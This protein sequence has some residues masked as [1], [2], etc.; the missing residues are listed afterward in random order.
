MKLPIPD[1]LGFQTYKKL[2]L[3][4]IRGETKYPTKAILKSELDGTALIQDQNE[5]LLI[6][7]QCLHLLQRKAEYYPA[8]DNNDRE[9]VKH[10]MNQFNT[11]NNNPDLSFDDYN[12]EN[13][14]F[15]FIKL[16]LASGPNT[17]T[18]VSKHMEAVF[19]LFTT[20]NDRCFE[21]L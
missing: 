9:R 17:H 21:S 7:N 20:I 6:K 8:T 16:S 1:Q 18:D 14:G 2:M 4:C 13:I 11:Y 15:Y 3:L 5:L 12:A 19:S 10:V